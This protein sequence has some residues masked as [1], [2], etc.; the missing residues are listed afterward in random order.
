[1][2]RS[3]AF[4]IVPLVV[5]ISIVSPAVILYLAGS[6]LIVVDCTTDATCKPFP[7]MTL[8][9]FIATFTY[10]CAPELSRV[11]TIQPTATK[12][13]GGPL[14]TLCDFLNVFISVLLIAD[15]NAPGI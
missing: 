12:Y 4:P 3:E 9:P 5:V 10:G 14:H 11:L 15:A 2:V 13:A 8:L 6:I 1:M 7:V